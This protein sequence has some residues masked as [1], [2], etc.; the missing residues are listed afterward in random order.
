MDNNNFNE[1]G[2]PE[3]Q[4][5]M[6]QPMQEMQQPMQEMP[7]QM[8]QMP[9]QMQQMQQTMQPEAPM[10][11]MYGDQIPPEPPKK[12]KK[13]GL[14]IGIVAAVMLI[15]I[16][17]ILLF[18][19]FKKTPEEKVKEALT[20]TFAELSDT[21]YN[22]YEDSLGISEIDLDDL[23]VDMTYT[24]NSLPDYDELE[25]ASL[26]VSTSIEKDGETVNEDV[27]LDIQIGGESVGVTLYYIDDVLYLEIPEIFGDAVF[28]L[29][30]SEILEAYSGTSDEAISEETE[31]IND[32]YEENIGD[33]G[34]NLK[35]S[36]TYEKIG[37]TTITNHNG[38]DVK[39][40]EYEVTVPVEAVEDYVTSYCDYLNACTDEYLTDD[41]LEYMDLDM[42]VSELKTYIST[43]QEYYEYIFTKDFSYTA[44]IADDKVV[45]LEA[46]YGISVLGVK[47]EF[48]ADFMGEDLVTNDM[49]VS[50]SAGDAMI[51]Y[52]ATKDGNSK[53]AESSSDLLLTAS[54]EVVAEVTSDMDF[55]VSSGDY[56]YV[57]ELIYLDE[58][59]ATF[60]I[61]GA[62]TNINKGKSFDVEIDNVTFDVDG[63]TVFDISAD[64][65]YG[66]RGED[67][68]Q[69]DLSNV[70]DINTIASEELDELI[71]YNNLSTILLTWI[72]TLDLYDLIDY[73][74]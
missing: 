18:T 37:K 40:T 13:T 42:T 5:Q 63:Y 51:E 25:G 65:S 26:G 23:D 62:I 61:D 28:E 35:E 48:L 67:I 11:N 8:Q 53:S 29:D 66:N 60:E 19:V 44:Y 9:P 30:A 32:L 12:K 39:C 27:S 24:I 72:E 21:S 59:L 69:P 46:D 57:S 22:I 73:L 33:S 41:I 43:I 71:D 38:D 4:P 52:T 2:V 68:E 14:I 70:Y 34:E 1:T 6:Q 20:N 47:I 16:A 15:A 10:Y 49:Y 36:V 31:K 74:Y 3:M 17:V 54:D 50:L 45:R 55:D 7:P 64:M 56:T 58:V